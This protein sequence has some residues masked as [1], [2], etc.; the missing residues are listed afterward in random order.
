MIEKLYSVDKKEKQ[1]LQDGDVSARKFLIEN[2]EK[3]TNFVFSA[4][5]V[6]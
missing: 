4:K 1:K 2:L 3:R 5:D 6:C